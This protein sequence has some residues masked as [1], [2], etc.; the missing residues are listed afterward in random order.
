MNS[1]FKNIIK[2]FPNGLHI[3]YNKEYDRIDIKWGESEDKSTYGPDL[4]AALFSASKHICSKCG[5]IN[6]RYDDGVWVNDAYL[7]CKDCG[8]VHNF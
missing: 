8:H 4:R 5:S 7:E 2:Q 3:S 1:Q 6:T